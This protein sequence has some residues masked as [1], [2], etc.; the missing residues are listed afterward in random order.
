M[1]KK[2]R[3]MHPEDAVIEANGIAEGQ[4][5]ARAFCF[6]HAEAFVTLI[7]TYSDEA[8]HEQLDTLREAFWAVMERKPAQCEEAHALRMELDKLLAAKDPEAKAVARVVE[9]ARHAEHIYGTGGDFKDAITPI[10][11]ALEGVRAKR[12]ARGQ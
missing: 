4:R 11:T 3:K 2:K 1:G 8:A 9:A 12:K 6:H 10:V 7:A 5:Y